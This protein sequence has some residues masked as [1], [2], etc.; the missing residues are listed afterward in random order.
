ME[1]FCKGTIINH[2]CPV[3]RPHL[4]LLVAAAVLLTTSCGPAAQTFM[5]GGQKQLHTRMQPALP[6]TRV[7]VFAM[8]GAG[9]DQFMAALSS[10][11]AKNIATL[12]GHRKGNEI[13]EHAYSI[14]NAMSILPTT[15]PAWVT[16]FTGEPPA[17]TGVTGDE[18]FIREQNRFYAPV[19]ISVETNED[20]YR[21]LSNDLLG[22]LIDAPTIYEMVKVRSYVSLNGV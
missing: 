13:F 21:M 17:F 9:Y 20:A 11:K 8:D 18:F 7:L 12:M 6:A 10:G 4:A 22:K 14:A 5:Q 2:L 3:R 19:P 15:M 16:I 1:P